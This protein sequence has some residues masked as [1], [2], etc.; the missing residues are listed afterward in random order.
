M[1]ILHDIYLENGD[2]SA[3]IEYIVFTKKICFVIECKNLYGDIEINSSGDF[4]QA[5]EFAGTKKNEFI[6]SPITQNK[7]KTE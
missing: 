5:T 4:I 6:Y 7:R 2:L 3:Q 1:Y